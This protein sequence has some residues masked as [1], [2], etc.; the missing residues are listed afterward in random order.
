MKMFC[1]LTTVA[2]TS[3]LV[4]FALAAHFSPTLNVWTFS[5][6]LSISHVVIDPADTFV[7]C[8]SPVKLIRVV[9]ECQEYA[10]CST[11]PVHPSIKFVV[12]DKHPK[13]SNLKNMGTHSH[14]PGKQSSR[15]VINQFYGTALGE[16]LLFPFQFSCSFFTL[17]PCLTLTHY[18][19][20]CQL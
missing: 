9:K 14:T 11:V 1:S 19:H 15:E 10:I 12:L 17:S 5:N 18:F 4:T 3:F 6:L 13:T 7:C 16:F 2:L 8:S 20:M